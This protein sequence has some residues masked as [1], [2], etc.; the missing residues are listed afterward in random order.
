LRAGGNEDSLQGL[1]PSRIER[2]LSELKLRPPKNLRKAAT[3]E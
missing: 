3:P 2:L 1:K